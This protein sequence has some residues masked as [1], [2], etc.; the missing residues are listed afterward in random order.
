MKVAVESLEGLGRRMNIIV[1]AEQVQKKYRE[2][3]N[4]LSK[5]A[6]LNGFRPGKA[7]LNVI[8]QRFGEG[9]LYEACGE[10]VESSFQQA[11]KENEIHMA[12]SP[13]LEPHK[14]EKNQDLQYSAVF[15][16]YPSIQ[17]HDLQGATI[18][19]PVAEI[20][21][22][23]LNK[24]LNKIREQNADWQ[25]VDRASHSGDRLLIDFEGF[26]EGAAF[27][28]GTATQFQ[29][30]L[31]SK[32]M[33]PGFE[34]ALL[35]V[36][37]GDEPSIHVTFPTDYHVAKLAGKPAEF[38]I[39]VH[40][41]LESKL[42]ELNDALVEKMGIK[43]GGVDKL[44][45]QVRRSMGAELKRALHNRLKTQVLEKL[46]DL[47]PTSLPKSAVDEEIKH[48]QSETIH[49]IMRESGMEHAD[50][51]G[52]PNHK[53]PNIDLPREAFVQQAERRIA[54]GLLLAEVIKQASIKVDPQQVRAKIEE[55]AETYQNPQQVID[56]YYRNQ[57]M[58]SEVESMLLE[59]AAIGHLL[60][61]AKLEE[62]HLS[63]E[64]VVNTKEG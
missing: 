17:L 9:V 32:Q 56:W 12:G 22:E 31:G 21:D 34:E 20:K 41:V 8:E 3:L 7:P 36:K 53:H 19:K 46:L 55:L 1:P 18:E 13:K 42:P 25:A 26:I 48:L 49:R 54:L 58:M 15:E 6:K 29:L 11:L 38:K 28:G 37:A 27:E 60:E 64:D 40:T 47:N 24:V 44:K 50:D 57:K 62:K 52:H 5:T 39:K 35:K 16:V 2:R 4:K 10:L 33:I 63:Y 14:F 45:E 23:D 51:H 61:K 30:Q 43:E 59:E